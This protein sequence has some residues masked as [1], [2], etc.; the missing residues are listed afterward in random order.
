LRAIHNKGGQQRALFKSLSRMAAF[1]TSKATGE[2]WKL[3]K[4]AG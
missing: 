1:V 2:A 3:M 4:E